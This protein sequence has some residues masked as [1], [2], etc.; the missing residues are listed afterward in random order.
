MITRF[1]LTL[2]AIASVI[3]ILPVPSSADPEKDGRIIETE[4]N[5]RPTDP[6]TPIATIVP[7][8]THFSASDGIRYYKMGPY[9]GYDTPSV[10]IQMQDKDGLQSFEIKFNGHSILTRA[11]AGSP[12]THSESSLPVNI[13]P[14][15]PA[16]S[17]SYVLEAIVT[18]VYGNTATRSIHINVDVKEPRI[19]SF[20]PGHGQILYTSSETT[21]VR[22]S[23]N[24]SD[25]FSGVAQVK[26]MGNMAGASGMRWNAV[27]TLSP[28]HIRIPG[29]NRGVSDWVL[30]V[31]DNAGVI[32]RQSFRITVRRRLNLSPA[33]KT[34][35]K[36]FPAK[37]ETK[38]KK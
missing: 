4:E 38:P 3:T 28:Y 36:L 25:D 31:K 15:R 17:G 6:R 11:I 22:W 33:Q 19:V 35:K 18:N 1:V 30:E 2:I 16:S 13:Y 37:K 7:A 14:H 26:I 9:G 12:Q 10:S 34:D 8:I 24:A 27:D 20:N 21:E 29:V 5:S 23:V 32:N